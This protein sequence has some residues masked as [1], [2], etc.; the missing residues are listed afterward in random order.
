MAF[1]L[2]RLRRMRADDFSRRL[3]RE[4]RLST[5]DLIHPL[6]VVEGKKQRQPIASRSPRRRLTGSPITLK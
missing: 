4:T 5:D 3:V 1:P 2:T 6:F